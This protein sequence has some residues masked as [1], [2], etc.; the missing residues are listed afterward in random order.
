MNKAL[1]CNCGSV[2]FNL[3]KIG[4]IECAKCAKH[5]NGGRAKWHE[6]ENIEVECKCN[7]TVIFNRKP[8]LYETIHTRCS[9]GHEVILSLK[10]EHL[11]G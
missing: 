4:L 5:L 1:V 6:S 11:R 7:K 3:L 2:K 10:V 8:D 9:N